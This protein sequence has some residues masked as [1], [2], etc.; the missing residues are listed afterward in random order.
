MNYTYDGWKFKRSFFKVEKVKFCCQ[1]VKK[2]F[3]LVKPHSELCLSSHTIS[4]TSANM[5]VSL[6]QFL[7]FLQNEGKC[8]QRGENRSIVGTLRAAA[9]QTELVASV[10]QRCSDVTDATIECVVSLNIFFQSLILQQL[11]DKLKLS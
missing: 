3:F 7:W 6:A 9:Q 4:V 2:F 1:T 10:T 11:C 5:A 8:F